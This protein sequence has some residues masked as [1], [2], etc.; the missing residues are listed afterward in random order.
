MRT[1][2]N[3][4]KGHEMATTK[5]SDLI[6]PE[7]L[8]EAVQGEFAGKLALFGESG[9]VFTSAS[10][11]N[12]QRGGDVI[13]IPYFG[14]LGEF[15][16][17][18][19]NEGGVGAVPALTPAKLTMSSDTATVQ[20]SGKAFETT[21]WALL[22]AN[23]ADP[24]SEAAR[25][26]KIGLGRRADLALVAAASAASTISPEVLAA[27]IT[28]DSVINAKMKW[29]DEQEDIALMIVHSKVFGDMLKLKDTTGQPLV[30]DP[31]NGGLARFAG[32]PVKV[33]DRV[34]VNA[35][36]PNTY[37]NLLV[38][39]GALAFWYSTPD[40]VQVD[41][42]ILTDVRVAAL[43]VYWAA[44]RYTRVAGGTKPGVITLRTQ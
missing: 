20:H 26:I 22:A 13:K 9:T 4:T 7:I 23:Y 34:V 31:V 41:K 2:A 32:I 14:T 21:E 33:S 17:L 36:S 25:Q 18:A 38:K 6:I 1:V 40:D 29:G 39:R 11:P 5:K 10:L 28:Y 30:T 24:Y 37:D 27:T 12:S 16:D 44:H 42:D 19:T 8:L 3:A 15:E 35:G 43:H